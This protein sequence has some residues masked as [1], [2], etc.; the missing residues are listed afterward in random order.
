MKYRKLCGR[1]RICITGFLLTLLAAGLL[2]NDAGARHRRCRHHPYCRPAYQA[3]PDACG[4]RPPSGGPTGVGTEQGDL[5]SELETLF[6]EIE[7]PGPPL[8]EEFRVF[9]PKSQKRD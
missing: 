2:V 5:I 7:D 1:T 6:K 4:A 3:C 9:L 8:P